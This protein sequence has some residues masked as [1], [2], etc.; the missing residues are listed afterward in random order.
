MVLIFILVAAWMYLTMPSPEEMARQAEARRMADSA[1]AVISPL[2][3]DASV[4]TPESALTATAEE[5]SFS[6]AETAPDTVLTTIESE[7]FTA[8]FSNIGAGPV[9]IRFHRYK[10]WA[11]EQVQLIADTT[12]SAYSLGFIST[13][14]QN[15]ELR[16]AA[17]F[18]RQPA[19]TIELRDGPVELVYELPAKN[20]GNIRYTYSIAPGQYHFSLVISLENASQFIAGNRV[21]F[22]FKPSLRYS[23]KSHVQEGKVAAAV[24]YSG[25]EVEKLQLL[26]A[27]KEETTITGQVDWIASKTQFFTQIV[28]SKTPTDGA[29]LSAEVTGEINDELTIH[30]YQ[31]LMRNVVPENGQLEYRL[32]VGPLQYNNMVDFDGTTFKMVDLGWSLFRWFSEPLAKYVFIQFFDRIAPMIGNYGVAILLLG[33]LIKLA[34]WPLTKKSFESMAAMRELQPELQAIQEKFKN[35]PQKQQEA[36]MKLYKTAKVNPL[37][38]CL[39]NL[40]QMPILVTLWAYFQSAIEIRQESF[41]WVSDLSAPDFIIN[42]PF[43]IP[44]LGSGIGGFCILMTASMVIQMRVSGQSGAA[45]PQMKMMQWMMPG[46]LFFIFNSFSAGLNLYYFTYNVLSIGHQYM[47]NTKNIDHEKLMETVDKKKAK[48]LKKAGK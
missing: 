2:N 12:R 24:A 41:L 30:R 31:A 22:G 34:L 40:L 16:N 27:G 23:E 29:I 9:S 11:G 48:E 37:G 39:P 19:G 35:D 10:T 7:D 38:G 15:V 33:L 17:F 47:I 1:A 21:E 42:L 25:G 13:G 44:F 8:V 26:D 5:T 18:A 46:M 6:L 3:P 36:L 14:N 20:G 45:N 43:E 32:Y 4:Q 28:A